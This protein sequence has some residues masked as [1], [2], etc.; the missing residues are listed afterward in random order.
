M[1]KSRMGAGVWLKLKVE[2]QNNNTSILNSKQIRTGITFC[3]NENKP[4]INIIID[5]K[6]GKNIQF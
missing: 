6:Y 3:I 1:F 2:G 4:E 5:T